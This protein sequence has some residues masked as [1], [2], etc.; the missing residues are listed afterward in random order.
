MPATLINVRGCNGSGK[1]TLLRCLARS[2]EC[3][4]VDVYQPLYRVEDIK[5]GALPERLGKPK[6]RPIQVTI[7]P[8]GLAMLG[9]YTVA[10][11]SST[12]AGCDRISRQADIKAALLAARELEGVD[13]V[14]FEGVV[15][16]TIFGPWWKFSNE[17]GT[18][19]NRDTFGWGFVWAFLDT[20]LNVCLAR[21][22]I[23]NG[24]KPIQED[25]VSDKHRGIA[26]VRDKAKEAGDEWVSD[27]HWITA[28]KD[29][30][31][32][33]A[34]VRQWRADCQK[35]YDRHK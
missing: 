35:E 15:V 25:L 1:T 8:D 12:T 16:S 2:P 11:S 27:I 14:L 17:V 29:I 32:L 28:L 6:G 22:Q 33:I 10:A 26:R 31:A 21:V 20:P 4:L 30:K 24:G 13:V 9:D 5:K 18:T 34:S 3:R 23:R 19:S 7:T